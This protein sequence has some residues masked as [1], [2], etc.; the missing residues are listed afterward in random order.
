M[1]PTRFT[2]EAGGTTYTFRL[3]SAMDMIEIDRKASELRGGLND[4]LGLAVSYSHTIA[5]LSRLCVS[6]EGVDFGA[7]DAYTADEL[8]AKLTEWLNS[9]RANVAGKAGS[10]GSGSN[11]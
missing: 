10:V 5:M 1:N 4:G 7:M 6:P 11:Q 2:I 9:F 3:P 8:A